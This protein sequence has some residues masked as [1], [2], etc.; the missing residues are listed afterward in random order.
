WVAAR[1]WWMLDA[2]GHHDVAV[3]DGGIDAWTAGGGILPTEVP[4]WP[5]STLRLADA[6]TGVISRE[7]L[8]SRLG[9][10]VL[11]DARAAPRYRGEGEPI[12]PVAGPLPPPL[13]APPDG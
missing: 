9:S 11:L 6:W 4:S 3:L 2:L 8:K 12:D 10:V 7:E 1:L 5:P 13:S